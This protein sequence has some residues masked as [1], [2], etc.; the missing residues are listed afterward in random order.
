MLVLRGGQRRHEDDEATDGVRRERPETIDAAW[1]AVVD[2]GLVADRNPRF[3]P[4][5]TLVSGPD[6]AARPRARLERIRAH[7]GGA[8]VQKRTGGEP[9]E[10]EQGQAARLLRGDADGDSERRDAREEGDERDRLQFGQSLFDELGADGERRGR[11]V[12]AD[13][14]GERD[15]ALALVLHAVIGDWEGCPLIIVL[16]MAHLCL[17]LFWKGKDEAKKQ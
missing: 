10:D 16:A 7:L 13:G 17:G 5:A 15:D 2:D 14:G 11:L 8:D 12:A 3:R 6:L 9:L 1:G 4:L